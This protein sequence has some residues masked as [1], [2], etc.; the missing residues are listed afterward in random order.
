VLLAAIVW[1]R[2]LF[3][4]MFIAITGSVGKTTGKEMLAAMLSSHAPTLATS[5]TSNTTINVAQTILRARPWHRF[6]V[7][8][9]G[10]DSPGWIRRSASILHPDVAVILNVGRTH[11]DR[12]LSLD[13]TALEKAALLQGLRR[14]GVAILNQDD[15]RVAAMG[16]ETLRR[17]MVWFGRGRQANV[18][19][20]H[21]SAIW[22]QRLSLTL[23]V[24]NRSQRVETRLVGE[25]WT[26]SLLGAAAAALECG[27]SL[28]EIAEAL[29]RV[30]PFPARL[31][32]RELP[33]GA[34][35]LRD[36]FNGSIESFVPAFKV[37]REAHAARKILAITTVS[38]SQETWDKRLRRIACD[39]AQVVDH[40]ILVGTKDDAKRAA[41]KVIASGFPSEGLHCFATSADAAKFL[42]AF[43]RAGDLLLLRG[44]ISDHMGRLYHAQINSVQCWL[45]YC[46]K[47]ILCEQCPE[48]FRKPRRADSP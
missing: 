48:L 36:D 28:Q 2:L 1:R 27:V 44:R 8:E 12:F 32:P 15:S 19:A 24:G 29:P 37:L 40:L 43:L 3:R 39:A 41:K 26:S 17:R 34:I 42:L 22:P 13:D 45:E 4:T 16:G 5:G 38:D 25:H 23:R 6:V 47:M 7:V 9:V 46:P 18:S 14:N 33:S 30:N 31:D 11:T 10:T 21:V 35:I 20:T